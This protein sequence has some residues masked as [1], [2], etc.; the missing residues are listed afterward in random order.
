MDKLLVSKRQAA[1]LLGVSIR[2][3]ENLISIKAL[4]SRKLGR[5]RLI[6]TSALAQIAR[7]GTPRITGAEVQANRDD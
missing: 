1:E 3:V 5:R 4:E 7:R 2:T 6:P